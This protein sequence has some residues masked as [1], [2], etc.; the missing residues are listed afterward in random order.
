MKR[1]FRLTE[2]ELKNMIA[3][4]VKRAIYEAEGDDVEMLWQE[5]KNAKDSG[6]ETRDILDILHRLEAAISALPDDDPRAFRDVTTYRRRTPGLG[7]TD[8][9]RTWHANVS[10]HRNEKGEPYNPF[11]PKNVDGEAEA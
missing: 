6:A 9:R 10:G 8:K 11:K 1:T 7:D 5:L 2:K 3:E 4:S